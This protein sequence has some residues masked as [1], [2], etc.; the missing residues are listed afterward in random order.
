MSGKEEH[1]GLDQTWRINF[2]QPTKYYVFTGD[3]RECAIA[4]NPVEAFRKIVLRGLD[5]HGKDFSLGLNVVVNTRGFE[6]IV[7]FLDMKSMD[8]MVEKANEIDPYTFVYTTEQI[9]ETTGLKKH[10]KNPN[11]KFEDED[12]PEGFI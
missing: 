7:N 9:L 3:V 6:S 1:D 4:Q 5:N 2:E 10:F 12:F 11:E 8:E